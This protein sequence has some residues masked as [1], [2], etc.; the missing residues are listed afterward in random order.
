MKAPKS[1][2]DATHETAS[3]LFRLGFIDKLAKDNYDALCVPSS[4]LPIGMVEN[5]QTIEFKN[6]EV[7]PLDVPT[8]RAKISTKEIVDIIREGRER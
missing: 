2:L 8:I 3:D 4:P 1:I 5:P 6:S 7:S